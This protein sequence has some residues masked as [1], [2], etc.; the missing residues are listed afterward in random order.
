VPVVLEQWGE[1]QLYQRAVAPLGW[2]YPYLNWGRKN[3]K[4]G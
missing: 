2:R 1:N 3:V 4:V